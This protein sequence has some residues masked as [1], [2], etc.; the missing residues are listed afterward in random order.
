MT[1]TLGGD[2]AIPAPPGGS[3][4]ASPGRGPR[5]GPLTLTVLLAEPNARCQGGQS[6]PKG[7]LASGGV[8]KNSRERSLSGLITILGL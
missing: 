5:L 4:S 7:N 8:R 2:T 1:V 6:R 3:G